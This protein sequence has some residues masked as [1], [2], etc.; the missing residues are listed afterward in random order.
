MSF[1][2]KSRLHSPPARNSWGLSS[3]FEERWVSQVRQ[4]I[5]EEELEEDIGFPVCICT[6]PKSL[7]A[8]NPESYTPQE[9]AIGPYHHW[10]QEL[11]VMERYKIAAAKKAQK[12]L[13]GLK[14][15]NLVEKLTM[16][17]EKTRVLRVYTIREVSTS[18]A[19][20]PGVNTLQLPCLVDYEGRKSIHNAI[21]RDIVILENQIPLFVLRKMLK[22]QS[23]ALEPADQL[24]LSMLLGLYEDLS[25]F[26]MMEDLVELQVSVS[27]CFH[28]LDFLCIMITP[29]LADSLEIL[30]NDQNQKESAKENIENASAFK[31]L[32]ISSIKL[33]SEIWKILSK[34][35]KGSVHLFRRIVSSRPFELIFKLPWTI[36]SKVPGIGILMK[37]LEHF[38]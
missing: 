7:M 2:S 17:E 25:P 36:I 5:D 38:D 21:L 6:V 16:Y 31:L 24:L 18:L 26:K 1:S 34:L 15:H 37:P 11:Y 28:L 8:I 27:E 32:C 9:V 29:E 13:Q 33:G 30:E 10:R 35:N 19:I 3:G 12:Q 20:D 22:L 23:S 14:F 4:S